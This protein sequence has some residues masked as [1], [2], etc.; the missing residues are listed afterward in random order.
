ARDFRRDLARRA[1]IHFILRQIGRAGILYSCP[2]CEHS[3]TFPR[4]LREYPNWINSIGVGRGG[5]DT[6]SAAIPAN[7]IARWRA[8]PPKLIIGQF[9][10]D[11]R[12][13]SGRCGRFD[14]RE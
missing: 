7:C 11:S 8:W 10:R 9:H 3:L 13:W 12:W 6:F 1:Q 5:C 14:L 2:P 4:E